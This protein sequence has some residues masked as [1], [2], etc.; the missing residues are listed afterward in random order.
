MPDLT[1]GQWLPPNPGQGP[2]LPPPRSLAGNNPYSDSFADMA[3]LYGNWWAQGVREFPQRISEEGWGVPMVGGPLK[4]LRSN[5]GE[6][7][8]PRVQQIVDTLR[9][10]FPGIGK[11]EDK[12][13]YTVKGIRQ[14]W[15]DRNLHAQVFFNQSNPQPGMRARIELGPRA[16]DAPDW[17]ASGMLLHEMLH[18]HV[19]TMPPDKMAALAQQAMQ[20]AG[21]GRKGL[22]L[23]DL[24]NSVMFPGYYPNPWDRLNEL[25]TML[26]TRNS[27]RGSM[28]IQKWD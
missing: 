10:Y 18:P 1:G 9:D 11:L 14:G 21:E 27:G 20:G 23:W 25:A 6:F 12:F 2:G 8:S 16:L 28:G 26:M 7:L 19:A 4:V 24:K 22:P 15:P 3:N 17:K 13:D 5:P